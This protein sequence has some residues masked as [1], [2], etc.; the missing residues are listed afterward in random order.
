MNL[1]LLYA[2]FFLVKYLDH[3]IGR[4]YEFVRSNGNRH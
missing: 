4:A 1:L 2:R 3:H